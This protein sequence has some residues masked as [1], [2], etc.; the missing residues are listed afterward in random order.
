MKKLAL[1]SALPA[2]LLSYELNFTKSFSKDLKQ[3]AVS[4]HLTIKVQD[5]SEKEVNKRLAKFADFISEDKSVNKKSGTYSISPKY[6]YNKNN[7][8]LDGYNGN[9]SYTFISSNIKEMND[10][11]DSVFELKN[12]KNTSVLLSSLNWIVQDKTSKK[13]LDELRLET[14]LW[15][16]AYMDEL[17]RNLNKNCI[18][19]K[20]DFTNN[21]YQPPV[22]K[23]AMSMQADFAST[24][25]SMPAVKSQTQKIEI[26]PKFKME[27]K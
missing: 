11:L 9:L 15:A 10:F 26:N 5:K 4:T 16:D 13:A 2:L 7:P 3:D 6:I 23:R 17:S 20:V 24:E 25:S 27:C 1:L 21:S 22:Y 14:L 19:Q 8:I 18:V 12:N